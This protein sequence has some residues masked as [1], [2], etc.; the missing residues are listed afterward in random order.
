M[1]RG[2]KKRDGGEVDR[3]LALAGG[4]DP[5]ALDR[6]FPVVYDQ[7]RVLARAQLGRE[8]A[9]HTLDPTALVNEAY[10]KLVVGPQVPWQGRTHFFAI[11]ARAMRQVL[12]DYA[13]RRGAAKRGGGWQQ[14]T[15]SGDRVG[16]EIRLDELLSLDSALDRLGELDERLRQV[17]EYRFFA[18]LT[19]QEIAELLGVTERTVQRDWI[20][21]RAWLHKELHPDRA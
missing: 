7:L 16:F 5:T 21:A 15:L 4:G 6:L 10:L 13:R 20:K 8:R 3:L 11:A 9:G 19:E 17:V 1:S 2:G 12:I 18:G 14:T